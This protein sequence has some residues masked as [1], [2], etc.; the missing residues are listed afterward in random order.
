MLWT[1]AQQGQAA[2]QEFTRLALCETC[3]FAADR[4]KR[5]S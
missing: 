5:G 2:T 3:G 1:G 4:L